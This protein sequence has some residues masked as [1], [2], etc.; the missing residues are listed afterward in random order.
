MQRTFFVGHWNDVFFL[1]LFLFFN[2]ASSPASLTGKV[3]LCS[4]CYQVS[5]FDNAVDHAPPWI[6]I[7]FYFLNLYYI[8]YYCIF[9][10]N[11]S[12]IC[13]VTDQ[14]LW[15]L[16]LGS[17]SCTVLSVKLCFC[18]RKS[19]APFS[20]TLLTT[21]III[22]F[23]I[24]ILSKYWQAWTFKYMYIYCFNVPVEFNIGISFLCI[25]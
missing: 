19:I 15:V 2:Q 21:F 8:L 10:M 12:C 20:Y 23:S 22:N 16:A 5:C 1:F 9:C 17:K 11:F 6:A 4:A 24:I 25:H 14:L 13:L 7:L 3:L 18:S